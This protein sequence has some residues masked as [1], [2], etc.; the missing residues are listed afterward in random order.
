L[1]K[2][3]HCV[4]GEEKLD[5]WISLLFIL[6]IKVDYDEHDY[7]YKIKGSLTT[8]IIHKTDILYTFP[9]KKILY[10][11]QLFLIYIKIAKMYL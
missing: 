1:N 4:S 5:V 7:Y 8:I 3:N 10:T 11:F 9:K 6:F 2:I